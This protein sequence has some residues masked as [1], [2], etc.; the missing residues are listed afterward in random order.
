[1]P[2][3]CFIFLSVVLEKIVSVQVVKSETSGD[4]EFALLTIIRC[5]KNPAKYFAKVF[6]DIELHCFNSPCNVNLCILSAERAI[7]FTSIF[8]LIMICCASKFQT[9]GR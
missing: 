4:F 6:P 8:N 9:V 1:M 2:T 7:I 3:F 5:A